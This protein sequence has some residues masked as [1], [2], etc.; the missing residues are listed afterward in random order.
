MRVTAGNMAKH[1]SYSIQ[2]LSGEPLTG[3]VTYP[4]S[5]M[6]CFT[7]LEWSS[8]PSLFETGQ[9]HFNTP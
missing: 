9:L 3:V 7:A 8:D 1:L 2:A 5:E 6:Q 4:P